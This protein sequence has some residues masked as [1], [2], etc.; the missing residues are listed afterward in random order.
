VEAVY[1]A[2]E[3]RVGSLHRASGGVSALDYSGAGIN[4]PALAVC[5]RL[6]K[7]TG[8]TK[9]PPLAGIQQDRA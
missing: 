9:S 7:P 8:A 1:R 3:F 6:P 4:S 5:Q 2:H